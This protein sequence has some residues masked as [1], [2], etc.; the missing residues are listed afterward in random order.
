V[1]GEHGIVDLQRQPSVGA[2][3]VLLV[4]RVGQRE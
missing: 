2:R 3:L 4:Q 1:I